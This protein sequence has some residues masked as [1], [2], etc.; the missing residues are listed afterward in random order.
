MNEI[1][2]LKTLLYR[3]WP[4]V[5]DWHYPDGK[6]LTNIDTGQLLKD[7]D[8]FMTN[9]TRTCPPPLIEAKPQ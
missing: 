2:R 3:C 1:N 7:M 9:T 6:F 4:A 5:W 8:E